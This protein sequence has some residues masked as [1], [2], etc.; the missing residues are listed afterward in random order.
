MEEKT[1][2]I[3]VRK[4][5]NNIRNIDS[6]IAKRKL[7]FL[8]KI[9]RLPSSK[10]SLR[11]ISAFCPNTRLQGRPNF[12]IRHSILNDI[13]KIIPI[14]DKNGSFH[15]WAHIANNKLVLSVLIN[16]IGI[17][18]PQSC[19]YSPEWEGEI[20]ESPPPPERPPFQSHPPKS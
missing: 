20:P 6:L 9:I 16:N 5:F 17:D 19:H 3:S 10:I 18:D 15:T 8:G 12:T 4:N 14:V 1:T 7:I 2:N 11:L 13:K